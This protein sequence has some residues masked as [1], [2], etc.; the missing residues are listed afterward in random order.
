MKSKQD[1]FLEMLG[2]TRAKALVNKAV[3]G[4]VAKDND[5]NKFHEIKREPPKLLSKTKI[6]ELK[7]KK[8]IVAY[9]LH[10]N[11]LKI[12]WQAYFSTDNS[13]YEILDKVGEVKDLLQK[14][15]LTWTPTKE[16][17]KMKKTEQDY[18]TDIEE[19]VRSLATTTATLLKSGLIK[20]KPKKKPAKKSVKKATKKV[21]SKR[22]KK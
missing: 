21:A 3:V 15:V 22:G 1:I 11:T 8:R 7:G 17:E 5:E 13:F 2:G 12:L 19:T 4:A 9:I 14:D 20:E 16:E 10:P 6:V 18:L